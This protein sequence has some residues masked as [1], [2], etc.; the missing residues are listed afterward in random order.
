MSPL[1]S[2]IRDKIL[3]RDMESRADEHRRDGLLGG[4]R[5]RRNARRVCGGVPGVAVH[6]V[7]AVR[8][9]GKAA[10]ARGSEL[11]AVPQMQ[12]VGDAGAVRPEDLE[13]GRRAEGPGG[14]K[15]EMTM[16]YTD[17][18][19]WVSDSAGSGRKTNAEQQRERQTK[20]L[21]EVRANE[22]DS[23]GPGRHSARSR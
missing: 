19:G 6:G 8:G 9:V 11:A 2:R 10:V 5:W 7:P 23:G 17:R 4:P 16:R 15:E 22:K 21:A 12:R 18:W 20:K 14:M 1:V 13:L 3:C